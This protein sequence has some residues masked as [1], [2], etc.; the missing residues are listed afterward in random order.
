[1]LT[2]FDEN[3][4]PGEQPV[5]VNENISSFSAI[6]SSIIVINREIGN[7]TEVGSTVKDSLTFT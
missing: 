4:H 6:L 7:D 3:S 1:M 2:V 5:K